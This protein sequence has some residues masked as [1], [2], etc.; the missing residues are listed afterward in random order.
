[1]SDILLIGATGQLGGSLL[2]GEIADRIIAPSR[3]E[4]DITNPVSVFRCLETYQPRVVINTAAFHNVPLCEEQTARAMEVNCLAV[5]H[6]A[7]I[8][9]ERNIRLITFSTDYVFDGKQRVPYSETDLPAPLQMYGISRLAGEQAAL[10]AAPNHSYVI[11]TSGLYGE[12]GAASKGGNFVDK[13]LAD[14]RTQSALDMSSDQTVSPTYTT[15]LAAAVVSLMNHHHAEPGIYHLVNQGECT[16]AEFTATIYQ[17]CGLT[18]LVRPIDRN[19]FS[20][21][22]RRPKY[23]VLGNKRAAEL[24]IELPHWRDALKRYLGRKGL[25]QTM[26]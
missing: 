4:L 25:L 26:E 23:S 10:A 14:A 15:D 22:M 7:G 24:K 11:R 16:W 9:A 13:R 20:G 5:Y 1:M 8:C 3:A 19:G 17:E 12:Q 21:G 2:S 6:L 18:T